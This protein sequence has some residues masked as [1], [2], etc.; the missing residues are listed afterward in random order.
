MVSK[1]RFVICVCTGLAL[2]GKWCKWR[3]FC[4]L[5]LIF[6]HC[7]FLYLSLPIL[8]VRSNSIYFFHI[9]AQFAIRRRECCHLNFLKIYQC[10]R[11]REISI[12]VLYC[13][14]K[15]ISSNTHILNLILILWLVCSL[16]AHV[17]GKFL[18]T[19]LYEKAL[20]Y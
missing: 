13:I 18:M 11:K 8:Q 19:T 3:T 17:S 15:H 9:A 20:K 6:F 10:N 14:Q 7:C 12:A 4:L 5:A 16:W 1:L 2:V